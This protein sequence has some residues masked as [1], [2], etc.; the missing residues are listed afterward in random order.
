MRHLQACGLRPTGIVDCW[1]GG[2][3]TPP[4]L[5]P[6]GETFKQLSMGWSH[7]CGVTTAD[8]I[9]CWSDPIWQSWDFMLPPPGAFVEAVAGNEDSCALDANGT[10]VCFGRNVHGEG[11]P[12]REIFTELSLGWYFACGITADAS[13]KCWGLNDFGQTDAPAMGSFKEVSTGYRHA[14][15]LTTEGAV[16]CWGDNQLGQA[17]GPPAE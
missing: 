17:S 7:A 12:P 16:T 14:C 1:G 2:E 6:A 3:G 15:A 5:P 9:A 11:Q 13:V 4:P 10:V 8:V